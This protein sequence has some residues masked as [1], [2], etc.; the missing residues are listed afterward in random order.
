M[1][2]VQK[3]IAHLFCFFQRDTLRGL[4]LSFRLNIIWIQNYSSHHVFNLQIFCG[5]PYPTQNCTSLQSHLGPVS[6]LS[7]WESVQPASQYRHIPGAPPPRCDRPGPCWPRAGSLSPPAR[8]WT[9]PPQPSSP[10]PACPSLTCGWS[11]T[12]VLEVFTLGRWWV[13]LTGPSNP[14][15]GIK[16]M[17]VSDWEC[18]TVRLCF[19]M[20]WYFMS[21]HNLIITVF[22]C[23]SP[24]KI[25]IWK[26]KEISGG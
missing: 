18:K 7:S 15:V 20:A 4:L 11:E 19:Y 22:R 1:Y 13:I 6:C 21:W 24:F 14:A 26:L 8:P 16:T 12:G 9:C 10:A 5:P 3:C 17:L 25:G 23:L 2:L